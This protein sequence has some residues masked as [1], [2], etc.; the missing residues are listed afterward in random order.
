MNILIVNNFLHQNGGSET[1]IFEIGK[2]LQKRGHNVSYFGM[3]HSNKVVGNNLNLYT[4]ELN[5]H[6]KNPFEMIKYPFK[7]IYSKEAYKKITALMES[8]NPDVVHLNNFTFQLTPSVIY[9]VRDYE[10]KAGKKIKI[11]YTAHDYQLVCPNHTMMNPITKELCEKC[12]GGNF[13]N[14]FS[15]K[16]IHSSTLKSVIGTVEA[17]KYKKKNTYKEIDSIICPSEFMKKMLDTNPVFAK[18]TT[19]LHNFINTKKANSVNKE[20]YVLYFG[21]YSEEKGVKLLYSVAKELPDINFVFAGKGELDEEIKPLQNVKNV[22]FKTGEELTNLIKNAKFSVSPSCW[23]E[24]CPFSVMESEMNLTPVLG[25]D[26]GGI[27]ELIKDGEN[28]ELFEAINKD[29]LKEKIISMWNDKEKLDKYTENCKDLDFDN[30]EEY[31]NKLLE[32]YKS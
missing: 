26:I 2:E 11:I 16:C 5:F 31:C 25:A 13:K 22:G 3:K 8:F 1:Y 6:T 20:N 27:P 7:I 30:T 12:I 14:C 21:R 23:Y 32:I 24:N 17:E 29:S 10:K 15:G 19:T 28:G 18:K 9:A 4:D